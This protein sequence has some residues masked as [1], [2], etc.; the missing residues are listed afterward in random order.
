MEK[1]EKNEFKSWEKMSTDEKLIAIKQGIGF[2]L[3][4]NEIIIKL[5]QPKKEGGLW[6]GRK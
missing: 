5:L 1:E 3:R 4:Q 6:L 2:I